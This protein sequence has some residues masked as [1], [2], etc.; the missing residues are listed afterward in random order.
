MACATD[1]KN[2]SPEGR[3]TDIDIEDRAI[4][5]AIE[6]MRLIIRKDKGNV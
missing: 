2:D 5:T 6:A 3:R 1:Y 4:R